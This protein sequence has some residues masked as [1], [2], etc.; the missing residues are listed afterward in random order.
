MGVLNHSLGGWEDFANCR[1][2]A[3]DAPIFHKL[4]HCFKPGDIRCGDR[5]FC[6]YELS[7]RYLRR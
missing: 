4:L 6:T 3:H 1:Q 2:S 5:G 7:A